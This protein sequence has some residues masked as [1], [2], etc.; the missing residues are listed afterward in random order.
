[1]GCRI[2]V[3]SRLKSSPVD[4][5]S[6]PSFSGRTGQWL[7]R[8]LKA[9][10]GLGKDVPRGID[11]AV[12]DGAAAVAV[13]RPLLGDP[14]PADCSTSFFRI[15][16]RVGPERPIPERSKTPRKTRNAGEAESSK[17]A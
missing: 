2:R 13:S 12:E 11:I 10:Y 15:P 6:W 8:A 4:E 16:C 5:D 9:H 7:L 17:S 3:V 14:C 1:M